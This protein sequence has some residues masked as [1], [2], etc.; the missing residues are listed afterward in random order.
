V[1]GDSA[2]TTTHTAHSLNNIR[3]VENTPDAAL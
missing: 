1:N 2:R 3:I